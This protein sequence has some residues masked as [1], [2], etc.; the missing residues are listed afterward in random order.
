M[1]T[2]KEQVTKTAKTVVDGTIAAGNKAVEFSTSAATTAADRAKELLAATK[3]AANTGFEKVS[4]FKLGDKNVGE[5]AKTTVDSVQAAV[6]VDQ[7]TEQVSKIR[8]QIEGVLGT[9]K[10]SFRPTTN[11]KKSASKSAAAKPATPKQTG[12]KRDL[13]ALTVAELRTM[14]AKADIAGRSSM[15]KADLVAALK[16]AGK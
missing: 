10:E 15:A 14:A 7:L 5:H 1:D 13:D 4:A 16:K 12:T 8:D 11:V 6:D 2:R 3:D 9:W